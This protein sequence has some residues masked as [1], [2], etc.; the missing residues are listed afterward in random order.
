M[1]IGSN[2]HGKDAIGRS[3]HGRLFHGPAAVGHHA[4]S[5]QSP[6]PDTQFRAHGPV[7]DTSLPLVYEPARLRSR[8][9][10]PADGSIP[11]SD[12]LLPQ[13]DPLTVERKN[14]RSPLP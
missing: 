13:R 9:V 11:N 10:F 4:S 8:A 2:G 5:W 1:G 3:E 14:A 7:W 12:G 6:L